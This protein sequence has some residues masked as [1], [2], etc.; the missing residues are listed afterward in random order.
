MRERAIHINEL[1]LYIL[2]VSR[3][4]SYSIKLNTGHYPAKQTRH[5][6]HRTSSA[7]GNAQILFSSTPRSESSIVVKYTRPLILRGSTRGARFPTSQALQV[8]SPPQ[9]QRFVSADHSGTTTTLSFPSSV[10]VLPKPFFLDA[11]KSDG[12]RRGPRRRRCS[13]PCPES[14]RGSRVTLIQLGS[15]TG[16]RRPTACRRSCRGPGCPP[17]VPCV[18]SSP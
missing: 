14:R 3:N 7:H 5:Q 15:S 18:S 13:P 17:S 1:K 10:T 11:A 16:H 9:Q 8:S 12:N 6:I 4:A 2:N